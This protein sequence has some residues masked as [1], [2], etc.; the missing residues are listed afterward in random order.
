[1]PLPV[2]GAAFKN[3]IIMVYNLLNQSIKFLRLS[4]DNDVN[5]Q[6]PGKYFIF[7]DI[8]KNHGSHD[9]L[10]SRKKEPG[11]TKNSGCEE[12]DIEAYFLPWHSDTGYYIDL[13]TNSPQAE[14]FFT[15][16]LSGCCVGVQ[17]LNEDV[18]RICH[19]N[20]QEGNFD[21]SD[22]ERY[23]REGNIRHWLIPEEYDYNANY[24]V[25]YNGY[26]T[27]FWGEFTEGRWMFYYQM[28]DK[29]IHEFQY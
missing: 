11:C 24:A 18:V 29:K 23:N 6:N 26:P 1:M 9:V 12:I 25:S 27:L 17:R 8:Q 15:A 14:L 3:I 21:K 20:I 5:V 13:P 7:T 2:S 28:P 10:I 4:I 16:Q 22:F 19:Y